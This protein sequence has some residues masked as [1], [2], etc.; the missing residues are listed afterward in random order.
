M[1]QRNKAE[2]V[3]SRGHYNDCQ[4]QLRYEV[5]FLWTLLKDFHIPLLLWVL[6]Q[7]VMDNIYKLYGMPQTIVC[8]YDSVFSSTFWKRLF[9]HQG[10]K[11]NMSSSYHPQTDDKT[12]VVNRCLENYLRCMP[13]NRP[14]H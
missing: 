7:I 4:F 14:T 11:F 9:L 8:D 3:A 5:I 1:C 6:L 2:T 10:T 12:E 13:G